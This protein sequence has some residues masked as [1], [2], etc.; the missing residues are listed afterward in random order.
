MDYVDLGSGDFLQT[1]FRV[2]K[3]QQV[4]FWKFYEKADI[5]LRIEVVCNMTLRMGRH[6]R[7]FDGT[8]SVL[9]T[10]VTSQKAFSGG[11]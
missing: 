5:K 3:L 9:S 1:V 8:I 11:Q 2:W 6:T 4:L 7:S 10:G